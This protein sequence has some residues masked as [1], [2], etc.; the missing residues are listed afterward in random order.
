MEEF[1]E[2]TF[3]PLLTYDEENHSDLLKTLQIYLAPTGS[4]K[5][6]IIGET[7]SR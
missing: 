7:T 5:R 2:K 1:C 6:F 4:P 3:L